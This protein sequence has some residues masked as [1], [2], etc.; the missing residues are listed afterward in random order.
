MGRIF[1]IL[2]LGFQKLRMQ[3]GTRVGD[4]IRAKEN[5]I[6]IL[7]EEIAG[8]VGLAAEFSLVLCSRNGPRRSSLTT[9]QDTLFQPVAAPLQDLWSLCLGTGRVFVSLL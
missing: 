6:G 3:T 2:V 8:G 4:Q 1:N 9:A 7:Q 5:A